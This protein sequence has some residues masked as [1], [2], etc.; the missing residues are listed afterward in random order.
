M[1]GV[2]H[3]VINDPDL[4]VSM[5]H[6]PTLSM[7]AGIFTKTLNSDNYATAVDMIGLSIA[8]EGLNH[9]GMCSKWVPMH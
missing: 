7:K 4:R 3:E 8:S 6:C 9:H 2:L 1:P 5:E